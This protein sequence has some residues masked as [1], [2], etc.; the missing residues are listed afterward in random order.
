[1]PNLN[2]PK[3]I[4]CRFRYGTDPLR[5]T[6]KKLI[7][8]EELARLVWQNGHYVPDDVRLPL[9]KKRL[10]EAVAE[11]EHSA[12]YTHLGK[13]EPDGSHSLYYLRVKPGD[14]EYPKIFA[15]ALGRRLSYL[16]DKTHCIIVNREERKS[17]L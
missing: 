4:I 15:S 17:L 16:S 2:L 1:M 5:P 12:L 7:K 14:R 9:D 10:G 11:L 3:L 6:R 13:D 8:E